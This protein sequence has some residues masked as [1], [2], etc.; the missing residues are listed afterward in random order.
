MNKRIIKAR[1]MKAAQ[2]I[3]K[4]N[5]YSCIALART[6]PGDYESIHKEP[7]CLKYTD[8]FGL[9]TNKE[10][11]D[12]EATTQLSRQLAILLFRESL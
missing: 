6:K 1:L 10:I 5:E 9:D 11:M 2:A 12:L 8:F 4:Y 3:F 7:L